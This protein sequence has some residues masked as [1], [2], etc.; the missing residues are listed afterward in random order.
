MTRHCTTCHG[1][2]HGCSSRSFATLA[3]I[4]DERERIFANAAEGNMAMPPGPNGPSLREREELA[5][6]L[7]CGAP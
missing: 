2:G 1:G 5:E 3:S 7:A 6:W 4:R